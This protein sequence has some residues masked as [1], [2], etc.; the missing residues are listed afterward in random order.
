L[1][2]AEAEAVNIDAIPE[3]DHAGAPMPRPTLARIGGP[4]APIAAVS[5][6]GVHRLC[7]NESPLG[8]STAAIAAATAV[9]PRAHEYPEGE[10]GDLCA[11]IG[12]RYGVAADRVRLGPGSD[13]LLLNTVLAL[14]GPGDEVIFSARGYARCARNALIAGATPVA[15]S[16]RDFRADPDAILDA[17]TPRTRLVMLANPDNPSGA[18]LTLETIT[19]LHTRLPAGVL[20]VLDGAYADYVRDP[21]YGDGGL[22]L[23]AAAPNVLVSRTFSKL[24]G[25]AGM[26]LGWITGSAQVL[27]AVAKVGPTFPVSIP[28]I[29]AGCAAL[30]DA[31]HQYA[32]RAH[33]DRWLPWLA[34]ALAA[35][36]RLRLHPS[37][38]NF[39]LIDFPSPELAQACTARLA[40]EGIL[41]R[42][43]L[44]GAHARQ[45]RISIGD[46][47]AL[48]RAAD[49]ILSFLKKGH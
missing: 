17:I 2:N 38:A 45:M 39:Q 25:L 20:L 10:G 30:A 42:N 35:D 15:A 23:S 5:R 18:M 7:S 12:A 26:R 28:A 32:A 3:I 21:A 6:P 8:P 14:A 29:A 22:G 13:L 48:T 36:P 19:A 49:L 46:G 40:D 43:F 27:D 24:F 41:V 11:A 37:Q 44:G 16:D 4:M 9:L 34:D 1:H 31:A 33:N 47:A